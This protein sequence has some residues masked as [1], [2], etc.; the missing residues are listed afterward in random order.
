MA[1][2]Q[3][4]RHVLTRAARRASM[5]LILTQ[6]R[7]TP[8]AVDH[9]RYDLLTQEA[10]RGVVRRVLKD[11][12]AKGLSG[13]H[14][15][16][17]SFATTAPGVKLSPRLRAQYAEEMT[18]VLQHQFW[19]LTVSDDT[20]EVGLS[21]NGIPE[22][23]TVPFAAIKGFFDPS[24][25]FGLQ[26]AQSSDTADQKP[27]EQPAVSTVEPATA[28]KAVEKPQTA[29]ERRKTLPA[30]ADAAPAP[31]DTPDNPPGS[32]EV[33]RLDRFRKK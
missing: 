6:C 12:A 3:P 15:F 20:F 8:M 23:L 18:I 29:S 27:T 31:D 21:F 13:E 32:A 22:R 1:T 16:F 25:N 9:I 30:P 4:H 7:G 17:I 26:F 2:T 28:A 11:A 14:H 19:D 33:V 24:V 5:P 10:M